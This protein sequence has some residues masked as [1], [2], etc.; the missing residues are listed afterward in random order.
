MQRRLD[1]LATARRLIADRGYDAVTMRDLAEAAGVTVATLYNRFGS[2][3]GLLI[4]A[5][6]EV[7]RDVIDPAIHA[8]DLRGFDLVMA[9]ALRTAN[10]IEVEPGFPRALAVEIAQDLTGAG[11]GSELRAAFRVM[12][13]DQVRRGLND[14]QRDGALV[15]WAEL[16]SLTEV[17]L[18]QTSAAT[19]EWAING[20]SPD[21]LRSRCALGAGLVVLGLALGPERERVAQ[22]V[23]QHMRDALVTGPSQAAVRGRDDVGG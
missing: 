11:S 21:W 19:A 14:M 5:V 10:I 18:L 1:V 15:D 4:A 16:D 6:E 13:R 20:K 9:G 3:N 12:H 8:A 17:I 23:E 7:F 2:K 22:F